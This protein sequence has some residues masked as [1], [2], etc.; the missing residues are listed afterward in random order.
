M[1]EKN[2][3]NGNVTLTNNSNTQNKILFCCTLQGSELCKHPEC[4]GYDNRKC[5]LWLT[6]SSK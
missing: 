2:K 5:T 3:T 4:T 1:N 6:H